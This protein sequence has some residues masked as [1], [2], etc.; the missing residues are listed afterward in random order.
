MKN[1]KELDLKFHIPVL[2][3]PENPKNT[4]ER[5]VCYCFN[6]FNSPSVPV[7]IEVPNDPYD[8]TRINNNSSRRIASISSNVDLDNM[9]PRGDGACEAFE[10][11]IGMEESEELDDYIERW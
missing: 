11:D 8:Q 7:I 2:K 10:R 6:L 3:A 9:Q 4:M 5:V 1:Q